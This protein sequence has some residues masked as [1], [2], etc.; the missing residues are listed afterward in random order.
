MGR[1][2]S[3]TFTSIVLLL[4]IK[5]A[6]LAQSPERII[7]AQ[8]QQTLSKAKQLIDLSRN[9]SSIYY[10][11]PLL[12]Q[13]E[14]QKLTHT[15]FFLDV[16]LNLGIAHANDNRNVQAMRIL[17]AVKE[18]SRLK[19]QWRIHA[20]ACLGLAQLHQK[21]QRPNQAKTNLG[22]ARMAMV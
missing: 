22:D 18:K 3:F 10:L 1:L 2:L 8:M 12:Q 7:P 6:S 20:E 15:S 16:T 14:E 11:S 9:D 17:N 4:G 13:L 21:L 5:L 19:G